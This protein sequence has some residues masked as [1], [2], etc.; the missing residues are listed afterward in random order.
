[1]IF[2]IIFISSLLHCI[3]FFLF[4]ENL[5]S[6]FFLWIWC[7]WYQQ[8]N[9]SSY[10]R[11]TGGEDPKGKKEKGQL[12]LSSGAKEK[13][14]IFPCEYLWYLSLKILFLSSMLCSDSYAES[15]LFEFTGGSI[16]QF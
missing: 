8:K 14:D 12:R 4:Y 5:F 16:L 13:K 7:N 9:K 10:R 6:F 1:M 11:R 3:Y 15:L 2:F